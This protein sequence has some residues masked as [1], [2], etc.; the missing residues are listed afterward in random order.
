MVSLLVYNKKTKKWAKKML[1]R[2]EVKRVKYEPVPWTSDGGAVMMSG[3]QSSWKEI[4]T[5]E[6]VYKFFTFF[7][8]FSILIELNKIFERI[9]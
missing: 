2:N 5:N 1:S 6:F 8:S 4:E 3:W 9:K 7:N